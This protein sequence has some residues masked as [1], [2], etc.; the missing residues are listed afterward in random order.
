M[1][2]HSVTLDGLLPGTTYTCRVIA[3]DRFNRQ[4]V[5]EPLTFITA[6][7][8]TVTGLEITPAEVGVGEP[9]TISVSVSNNLDTPGTYELKLQ[10]GDAMEA[11]RTLDLAGNETRQ[12]DIQT[13]RYAPGTFAVDINGLAGQLSVP[14]QETREA[15]F[16]KN[17]GI[18]LDTQIDA[19][20]AFHFL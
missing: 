16:P 15:G 19:G 6:G 18:L 5:S 9:V 11:I 17:K 4:T 13:V 20:A 12:V 10:I 3:E 1:T 14:G 2:D 8:F 7:A